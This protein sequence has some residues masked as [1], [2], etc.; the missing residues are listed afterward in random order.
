MAA[1]TRSRACA[2]T[3]PSLSTRETVLAPTPARAATSAM[4]AVV[5]ARVIDANLSPRKRYQAAPAA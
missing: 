2:L 4:V 1:S 3:W 5:R